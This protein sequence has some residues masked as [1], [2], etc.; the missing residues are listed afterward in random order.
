MSVGLR[1]LCFCIFLL[2]NVK[3]DRV[4]F[5]PFPVLKNDNLLRAARGE[6]V[7]RVPVWVMRQAGRYLPEFQELRKLHD[8][9]TVCRTPELACEVTM[10]PL[11]RF[12][13]DASI[14]FSDILVIPQALGLTV[15]MHA[16]VGPVLPQPIVVPED[17]KRL[18]PDGALSRLSYVGDAIT[19][20]RHKLEGRVPLI[21]FTGAPWT[22]M[23]YMIEGGGSKTMSKAKAWLNEHPEDS[24]LFL[25]LLTDAIVDYL[26][27]QVKAGAQMLQVFESSA[28]HLSKEQFLQWG[29]PY[30]KRI[31]DELVDRLTKK[32]IPVVPMTLFAK[33]AGHSLKE[34]SELG[35][36]VIGLDW[37]VDPLEARTLVG[38]NI[39]LQGNLDPQDMYRD[40]DELRNL[41][42]EMVH[43]F[44]KSR[45][46]A[47]LG[48]GITPQTP[49]TSME[50]LVEAVHKAL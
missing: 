42:T 16:G 19:M 31:R 29:V 35:Y 12:D 27:M 39:T 25:N 10:Q 23:G 41:T 9:F 26:E 28:E 21:G 20:M 6:V 33:G 8:F 2:K 30:L 18:T 40:P 3:T 13:L 15:E 37:T 17:L 47:N 5:Q 34:Q 1:F 49:I 45:Y 11:R 48:H 38:P 50:V 36:D 43:K 22:L 4:E 44:G 7:D 32:A 14:I 46:I 24:K